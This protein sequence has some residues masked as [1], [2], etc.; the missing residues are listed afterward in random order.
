MI[1][2][3]FNQELFSVCNATDF[4]VIDRLLSICDRY[5]FVQATREYICHYLSICPD[6]LTKVTK[7]LSNSKIISKRQFKVKATNEYWVSEILLG[8]A[9]DYYLYF[10]ALKKW[11]TKYFNFSKCLKKSFEK[12]KNFQGL[13]SIFEQ[14]V[15]H[16]YK[17]KYLSDWS[18]KFSAQ[19]EHTR[20][21]QVYGEWILQ[22]GYPP[23]DRLSHTTFL[24]K[25]GG[26]EQW[27]ASESALPAGDKHL[28]A[29]SGEHLLE[30]AVPFTSSDQIYFE[31]SAGQ[32]P[33]ESDS[34]FV[35]YEF[36]D[37]TLSADWEELCY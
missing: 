26:G 20:L 1:I 13:I 3:K 25:R 15:G 30:G 7:K 10:P 9:E 6:H 37:E 34:L 35:N 4:K 29:D 11:L 36:C 5:G 12:A 31:S 14:N 22:I 33:P 27:T 2:Q 21:E 19:N 23:P 8:N 28:L 18:P 17:N 32:L 24:K 16:I